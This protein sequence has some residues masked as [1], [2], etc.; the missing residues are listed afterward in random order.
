VILYPFPEEFRPFAPRS[1]YIRGGRQFDRLVEIVTYYVGT[2]VG[3]RSPSS[4]L[5][6]GELS[7]GS[8]NRSGSAHRGDTGNRSETPTPPA[9]PPATG[10]NQATPDQAAARHE[11]QNRDTR[12]E[13]T[14]PGSPPPSTT[15]S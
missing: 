6:S 14:T 15:P 13:S 5:R 7:A 2:T 3:R 9:A 1:V 4:L 11:A 8:A 10:A 12:E